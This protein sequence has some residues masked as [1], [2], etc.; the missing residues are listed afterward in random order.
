MQTT[1]NFRHMFMYSSCF[2]CSK[3]GTGRLSGE[4]HEWKKRGILQ[5]SHP[6]LWI[7]CL[8][9]NFASVYLEAITLMHRHYIFYSVEYSSGIMRNWN[10]GSW[11]LKQTVV[12][13]VSWR[14]ILWVWQQPTH[15]LEQVLLC[16][17]IFW[18]GW[19]WAVAV[20]VFISTANRTQMLPKLMSD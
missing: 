19:E 17:T 9:S 1:A 8:V 7:S 12:G 6:R 11:S 18:T 10:S 16:F 14:M 13:F 5:W 20:K 3:D 2:E 4:K 15:I